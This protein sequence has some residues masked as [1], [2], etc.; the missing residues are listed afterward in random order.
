V[1][2]AVEE[3]GTRHAYASFNLQVAPSNMPAG[4]WVAQ[5]PGLAQLAGYGQED[6][7]RGLSAAAQGHAEEAARWF[8]L[9]VDAVPPFEQGLPRL[10]GLLAQQQKYAELAHLAQRFGKSHTLDEKTVILLARGTAQ[11][12]DIK[13]ATQ[14]LE[15]ALTWQAPTA[16]MYSMLAGFYRASGDTARAAE[17]EARAKSL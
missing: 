16:E 14:V 9:A 2:S 3:K 15:S 11:S 10:V 4:L 8:G 17:F 12:G 6:Y 13:L 1:I 7:K 5:D